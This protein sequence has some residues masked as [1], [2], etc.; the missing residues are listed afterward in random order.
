MEGG[1]TAVGAAGGSA[2]RE[3]KPASADDGRPAK[4]A[5]ACSS[6]LVLLCRFCGQ[7]ANQLDELGRRAD[8][9]W[10]CHDKSGLSLRFWGHSWVRET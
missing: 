7:E 4:Q 3:R 6:S 10:P 8:E 1:A 2:Q 5:R 9:I